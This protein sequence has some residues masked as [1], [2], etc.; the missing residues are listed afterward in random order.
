MEGK[1]A[2]CETSLRVMRTEKDSLGTKELHDELYYGV[3]TARAVENFPIS[4]WKA[5]PGFIRGTVEIKKAATLV[6]KELGL[7]PND[8]AEAIVKAC[9][10]ILS[11][12]L[13]D[14]FVV[15]VFQ[16]G[17]GTSHN[18][19]INEVIANRA[20]ELSGH[21]KGDYDFINPNDHVNMGQSTNDVI[22]TAIRLAVL[23]GIKEFLL[24]LEKLEQ[25]FLKKSCE[26]YPVIKSG[27]THLQDATP[28]RLGQEFSGYAANMT[29]HKERISK[30]SENLY[31]IGLGGT[32]VG[33]GLNSHPSYRKKVASQLSLQTGFP[34]KP[35]ANYFEAMQSMAVFAFISSGVKNLALDLIR[36]ANDFR[37]LASGPNTG[38]AELILPAVQPGSSIMPGKVNPVLAEMLN[39]VCFY[40]VGCD[41][42]VSS[43]VQAGQLELNVMMPL[44]AYLLPTSISIL[45]NALEAFSDKCVSG[46]QA[47]KEKCEDYAEKSLAI[48]TALNPYVGYLKAAEI[49]K[50]SQKTGKRIRDLILERGLLPKEKLDEILDL[51]GMTEVGIPGKA[52]EK[53]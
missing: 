42:G 45:G 31:A 38:L 39:M 48:V 6:H 2:F 41:S 15:D 27:R 12:R 37:L 43:A 52:K 22:P 24:K 1:S 18:M 46:V 40:V 11:G 10:E 34:L 25:I 14:Q 16:A 4:G 51:P 21:K 26:L 53:V 49:A 17:A 13:M 50:E 33:T 44:L 7:L 5:H 23:F 47:D 32:A 19:N 29:R 28:I 3:Q 35:A 9:D 36:I 20:L 30:T 8:K